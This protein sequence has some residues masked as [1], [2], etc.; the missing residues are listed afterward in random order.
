MAIRKARKNDA[1]VILEIRG[2]AIKRQCVGH[3]SAKEMTIWADAEVTKEFLDAVESSYFVATVAGSVVGTGMINLGSGRVD[4]IFVHPK[5]MRTGI[6]RQM[7]S[8]LEKLALDAQLSQL[9]LDSTLNAV[10]FY[11]SLG[12]VGDSVAQYAS[13]RGFTLDCVPMIKQL[14]NKRSHGVC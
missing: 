7:M 5:H 6:G 14:P 8:H 2:A 12:F 11:R 3:Y 1:Q 9:S 4:A 10:A 13:P